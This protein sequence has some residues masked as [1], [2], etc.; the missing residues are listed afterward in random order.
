MIGKVRIRTLGI[1]LVTVVAVG[2]AMASVARAG[3]FDIFVT[4]AVLKGQSEAGQQHVFSFVGAG[5]F[6]AICDNASFEGTTLGLVVEDVTV[7]PTYSSCKLAG[8]AATVQM[9]GCKYTLTGSLAS[10]TFNMD[11]IDCTAGKQI[12][13]K[14]AL[15]TVDIGVQ[16]FQPHLVATNLTGEV[17]LKTTVSEI[18]AFQTGA[19]CPGGNGAFTLASLDGN[20]VVKAFKDISGFQVTKHGHEYIE[21]SAV[22]QVVIVTT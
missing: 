14:T 2:A 9:N 17:T 20:T 5:T 16:N 18:A 11:I 6:K 4:P 22:E 19:A 1:A 15:C 3:E 8:T 13:I 21:L 7:T 10:N 12:Q